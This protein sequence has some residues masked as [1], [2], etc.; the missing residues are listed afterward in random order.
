MMIC[1]R[2]KEK[3]RKIKD[4]HDKRAYIE[5]K[6][7]LQ[8]KNIISSISYTAKSNHPCHRHHQMRMMMAPSLSHVYHPN[9]QGHCETFQVVVEEDKAEVAESPGSLEDLLLMGIPPDQEIWTLM[10]IP[11]TDHRCEYLILV[12]SQH[13]LEPCLHAALLQQLCCLLAEALLVG[14]NTLHNASYSLYWLETVGSAM[15]NL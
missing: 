8:F 2:S 15:L 12:D 1:W 11:C 9:Q 4:L 3:K 13:L 7:Q 6:K 10:S 5:V 14:M